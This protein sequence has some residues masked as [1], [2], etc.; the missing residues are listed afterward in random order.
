MSGPT[1][2]CATSS[3]TVSYT[4]SH[5]VISQHQLASDLQPRLLNPLLDAIFNSRSP[6][7]GPLKSI[8]E[9]LAEEHNNY[10]LLLPPTHI[11]QSS[12]TTASASQSSKTRLIDL[13]YNDEDFIKS[14]IIKTSQPL[15]SRSSSSSSSR[16]TSIIYNTL[17]AKQLLTKNGMI[18]P[19]KG[20]AKSLSIRIT[21][22]DY[23]TAMCTYF[24]PGTSFMIIHI[25]D[26]TIGSY[27]PP[28][29]VL[30]NPFVK[31]TAPLLWQHDGSGI[32]RP[33]ATF[34]TAKS[35][36]TKLRLDSITFEKLL[37]LFPLLS[38]AVS[39]KFYRLFHHNNSQFEI[40]RL[41]VLKLDV[42]ESEFNQILETAFDIVQGSLS[43]ENPNSETILE[44]INNVMRT[45]PGLDLNK[46]IHEYIELNLYD[47]I[48]SRLRHHF[49]QSDPD[50]SL[51]VSRADLMYVSLN[52]LD[53]SVMKPWHINELYKR[54]NLA[55]AE[56]TKLSDSAIVNLQAKT[57]I[58]VKTIKL[59]TTDT[60]ERV[61]A[62]GDELLVDADT[63]MG[64]LLMVIIH[65]DVNDL[66]A[67]L[68]YTKHFNSSSVTDDGYLS[69]ILSNFDAVLLHLSSATDRENLALIALQNLR[70]WDAINAADVA[71]VS[72]ILTS[73]TVSDLQS[74]HF[75]KSRDINGESCLMKAVKSKSFQIYHML[76]NTNPSWFLIDDILFDVNIQTS[77]SLLVCGIIEGGQ[78]IS[79]HLIE[80]IQASTTVE[81]QLA[82]YNLRDALGRTIGHYLHNDI[83]LIDVL[84]PFLRWDLRDS[85]W[86][87]P[88]FSLWRCY[89]HPRYTELIDRSLRQAMLQHF[90]VD[91]HTDKNGNTLLHV[92]QGGL[93]KTRL[94]EIPSLD[95]NRF[96]HKNLSPLTLYVK[97]NREE[98]LQT[99]LQDKRLDFSI[100]DPLN[101]LDVFDIS[102]G[103][104]PGKGKD[105]EAVDLILTR[106]FFEQAFK[107]TVDAGHNV[108]ALYAKFDHA[109]KDWVVFFRKQDHPH[110]TFST[111]GLP[112]EVISQS[113]YLMK[114]QFP[115]SILPLKDQFF[116]NYPASATTAVF[117]PFNKF[118]VNRFIET[119]N[120]FLICLSHHPKYSFEG[121]V[122]QILSLCETAAEYLTLDLIKDIKSHHDVEKNA[123]GAIRFDPAK[124]LEIEFFLNF[125]TNDLLKF[126]AI[127]SKLQRT[128]GL[129]ER[130][131]VEFKERYDGF[132]D[133]WTS[134]ESNVS[135][136]LHNVTSSLAY[137]GHLQHMTFMLLF[138]SELM[139]NI[140]LTIDNI[141]TWRSVHAQIVECNA[142]IRKYENT[143]VTNTIG[144]SDDSA[145]GSAS[146]TSFFN[147]AGVIE[148]KETKYKNLLLSRSELIKRL[149]SLN[150]L[151]KLEH[152]TLAAEISTFLKFKSDLLKYSIAHCAKDFVCASEQRNSQLAA[153]LQRVSA[154]RRNPNTSTATLSIQN[155]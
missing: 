102:S 103:S 31:L 51:K 69:Y 18:F 13:C 57:E 11:L 89:D 72:E 53:V 106:F 70:V 92:I 40:V 111:F 60:S 135:R 100:E 125:S 139:V 54:I 36:N 81:E 29:A 94:L 120:T 154:T 48:W 131:G 91:S 123:V 80:T 47:N 143:H 43:P 6:K 78:Q 35:D 128:L 76:M 46:L 113:I 30:S 151:L 77:Q 86:Y 127:A 99:I 38:G 110:D 71:T 88:L 96:N 67:H 59:L 3:S 87:T 34:A 39:D 85:Q 7:R 95:V 147:L 121:S 61:G 107:D 153:S 155:R 97:Y 16:N 63:L 136:H 65:A 142:D 149:M 75:L 28:I 12:F 118:K 14:H 98:N 108:L 148:N 25:E 79:H 130:K 26:T 93:A 134:S 50:L 129:L 17:N 9:V 137:R 66:E 133:N 10:T 145:T 109:S 126:K 101:F 23:L 2:S 73:I 68:Y 15:S 138:V 22:I 82:Y 33:S 140:T 152:E 56:L 146:I 115:I 116:S 49:R 58:L 144:H 64:L 104:G 24:Q 1:E 37:R 117:P 19:G 83:D 119:L 32:P 141:D 84:G 8:I 41:G 90:D 74:N 132:I 27:T 42:V 4:N 45:Y 5:N 114:L 44:L 20:F 122:W 124:I 150:V 21:H 62:N 105:S 55:V 112:I 52:Q